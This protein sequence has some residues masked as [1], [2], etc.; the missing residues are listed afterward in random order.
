MT[1][2]TGVSECPYWLS[3]SQITGDIDE[4]IFDRHGV[5]PAIDETWEQVRLNDGFGPSQIKPFLHAH[6]LPVPREESFEGRRG[7]LSGDGRLFVLLNLGD[8]PVFL[9]GI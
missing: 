7:R 2:T 6:G 1:W 5:Q 3:R 8:F 9:T 4:S